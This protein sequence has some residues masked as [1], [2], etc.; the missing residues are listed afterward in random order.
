MLKSRKV[1]LIL[2]LACCGAGQIYKGEVL[3]GINFAVVYGLLISTFFITSSLSPLMRSLRVCILIFMWFMGMIDAY[4]DD[5][6]LM[7]KKQW[8][9]WQKPLAVLPV[10]VI[11]VAV[12]MLLMLWAHIFSASG[13]HSVTNAPVEATSGSHSPGNTDTASL[14]NISEY[15][16]V[17]VAAFKDFERA[18]EI[19]HELL[20]KGYMVRIEHSKPPEESWYRVFVG[21]FRSRE[22]AVSFAEGLSQ[23]E[24]LSYIIVRHRKTEP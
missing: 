14:P 11:S 4:I 2:S 20:L 16:S 21:E 23:K 18:N 17:Q 3:K 10:I 7:E 8:L 15:F 5:T 6:I 13:E 24:E 9:V 19:H 1:A 22:E 12:I